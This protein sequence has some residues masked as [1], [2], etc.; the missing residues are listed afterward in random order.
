M[1]ALWAALVAAHVVSVADRVPAAMYL[2]SPP[3]VTSKAPSAA[4]YAAAADA[5]VER[6][7]LEVWSMERAGVAP[8]AIDRCPVESRLSCW[9]KTMRQAPVRYFWALAVQPLPDGRDRLITFFVDVEAS[10]EVYRRWLDGGDPSWRDKAEAEIFSS[11]VVGAPQSL[12]TSDAAALEAYF[13]A[14]VEET[15]RAKLE[16]DGQWRPYGTVEVAVPAEG[17][18]LVVDDAVVGPVPRGRVTVTGV[19][20]GSHRIEGRAGKFV[21]AHE[22]DVEREGTAQVVFLPPPIAQHPLRTATLVGGGVVA[23]TGVAFGVWSLVR[24]NDDVDFSCV[25]R[26]GSSTDCAVRGGLTLGYDAGAAPTTIASDVNP[27]GVAMGALAGGLLTAGLTWALGALWWGERDAPPWWALL[28]GGAAG[29][30]A[31]GA[32]HILAQ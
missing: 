13:V 5:L 17:F 10:L 18:D 30:T 26:S 28:V 24:A 22:V 27:S 20:P 12:D 3:D 8:G 16:A 4:V 9:T 2:V 25:S 19:L 15:L 21:S 1:N 32:G 14:T 31:Y 6:T 29:V 7:G 11:S 23:A